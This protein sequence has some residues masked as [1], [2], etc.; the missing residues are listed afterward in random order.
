MNKFRARFEPRFAEVVGKQNS[1]ELIVDR[2]LSMMS[3]T[4]HASSSVVAL[5]KYLLHFSQSVVYETGLLGLPKPSATSQI[6][7]C[8]VVLS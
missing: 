4:F 2:H 8:I 7:I 5:F 6:C 3:S 1:W